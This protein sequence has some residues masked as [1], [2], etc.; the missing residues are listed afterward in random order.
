MIQ[1]AHLLLKRGVATIELAARIIVL[2]G[3][4]GP[5][6]A[7]VLGAHASFPSYSLLIGLTSLVQDCAAFLKRAAVEKTSL[8]LPPVSLQGLG[9][10]LSAFT[11]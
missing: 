9:R 10:G 6:D 3:Q 2:E 4:Q 7:R 5:Y 1:L 8:A 11:L